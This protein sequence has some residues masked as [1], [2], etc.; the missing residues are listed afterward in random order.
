MFCSF[1]SI[2]YSEP[3]IIRIAAF[4]YYPCIFKDSD[5]SIKGFYVDSLDEISKENNIRFE[6]VWGSWNDGLRRIKSGEVDILTSVAY[7]DERA[8]F[9]DYGKVPL[10]TVWGELYVSLK[11]DIDS[12]TDIKGKK[13]GLMKGDFNAQSFITL[14]EK[15]NIPFFGVEYNSFDEV[16]K[17]IDER[18]VDA[19]VVNCIF[20][21]A[22]HRKYGIRSTGVVFNPFNIYFTASKG[23]NSDILALLDKYL[24]V[25]KHKEASVFN[26]SRQKWSHGDIDVIEVIPDWFLSSLAALA[27]SS[28][29]FFSFTIILKIKVRRATED[30][31]RQKDLL[32]EN[33]NK[34]RSYIDN[35]P[36]GV[37]VADEFG[38]YI[39][40][41]PAASEM[42]GY[43]CAE[44]LTMHITDLQSPDSP[45]SFFRELMETGYIKKETRFRHKNGEFRWWIIEGIKLTEKRY[46]GF[47]RDITESR[48]ADDRIKHLLD[49]KELLLKEVH[50]RIKNNMNTIK[51]LL[52]LQKESLKGDEF[53]TPFS[54]AESR[55]QS[56]IILYDR[57]YRSDNYREQSIKEYLEKLAH[58]IIFNFPNRD[59]VKIDMDIEDFILNVKILAPLGIIINEILTNIM[60]YAFKSRDSGVITISIHLKELTATL[61]VY[62][63]GVGIPEEIIRGE[64][65]GFGL[66]LVSMLV[67][68]ISGSFEIVRD[69][70]TRITINFNIADQ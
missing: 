67:E 9:M 63:N 59:I 56:M 49:E 20:G 15:F 25:W 57:L 18:K 36:M 5:G 69:N 14:L 39:E 3:R 37:F 1:V 17:A 52:T 10:L 55:V 32:K 13:V 30:I 41:N 53:L 42:T 47:T 65:S 48:L 43:S 21:A 66:N 12:I 35:S 62:D 11:S 34:L 61:M 38:R 33:E 45:P 26:L 70:G 23:K 7:T 16:F 50:H 60:K 19:G 8:E 28:L 22:G 68:Q 58:E 6:Y 40:V 54:D 2:A 64:K 51:G 46:L 29:I 24:H 27:I 31:I 4:N 44:L